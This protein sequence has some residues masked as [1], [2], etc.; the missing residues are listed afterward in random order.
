MKRNWRFIFC[1]GVAIAAIAAMAYLAGN[2]PD[3]HSGSSDSRAS[4]STRDRESNPAGRLS[5]AE[6]LAAHD[7]PEFLADQLDFVLESGRI[8]D[9]RKIQS[10]YRDNFSKFGPEV[11][12]KLTISKDG[13]GGGL[14]VQKFVA[15][16]RDPAFVR[17][18]YVALGAEEGAK[19]D[20]LQHFGSD[21]PL[22]TPEQISS[23]LGMLP[24]L[25]DNELKY[26]GRGIKSRI[27]VLTKNSES[28]VELI[29]AYFAAIEEPQLLRGLAPAAV[30]AMTTDDAIE[31]LQEGDAE[32]VAA[33]DNAFIRSLGPQNYSKG[34][35]LINYF[36]ETDQIPRAQKATEEFLFRYAAEHPSKAL[37]WVDSL[38]NEIR[39]EQM[40]MTAFGSIYD[41]QPAEA[42]K[43]LES[44]TDPARREIYERYIKLAR[45]RTR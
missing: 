43:I 36:I 16:H 25:S 20:F 22:V 4:R 35:E 31:W 1:I 39:T 14:V 37:D 11:L 21:S 45:A 12:A 30:D 33:G 9:D 8:R 7:D 40:L 10:L 17:D 2:E 13:F 38:G 3:G 42:L 26:L 44:T 6:L 18:Y 27:T 19:L 32:L 15:S 29:N 41:K 34:I 23:M 28:K 24:K 5:R